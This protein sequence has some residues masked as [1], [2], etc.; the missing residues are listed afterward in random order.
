M[1]LQYR[2]SGSDEGRIRRRRI[3]QPFAV[4]S[5]LE[6]TYQ[7]VQTY[8]PG[9]F[10]V[11]YAEAR[12]QA[13]AARAEEAKPMPE[14]EIGKGKPGPGRPAK[15]GDNITRF[16]ED[17]PALG[18]VAPGAQRGTSAGYLTSRIA[19][20]APEVLEE[21]K[22]GKHASVRSA[23][24]KAGIIKK[25]IR[26]VAQPTKTSNV[27]APDTATAPIHRSVAA[28]TLVNLGRRC[29]AAAR[30]GY[31]APP[32][33]FRPSSGRRCMPP[34][35]RHTSSLSRRRRRGGSSPP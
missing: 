29:L 20:E 18:D 17:L 31:Q 1:G 3:K 8:A 4:W 14:Q 35:I 5:E 19:R 7:F 24:V 30:A 12:S 15:T 32:R 34:C 33:G 21:M 27:S 26:C 28:G 22:E 13:V 11:P 23:A 25:E 16:E 9:L 10:T 6:G 2:G